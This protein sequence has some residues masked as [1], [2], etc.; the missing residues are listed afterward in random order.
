M[1]Y[2]LVSQYLLFSTITMKS[3]TSLVNGFLFISGIFVFI[4][5]YQCIKNSTI[6]LIL[7][8]FFFS[9]I[10]LLALFNRMN[11]LQSIA[12]NFSVIYILIL[13]DIIIIN[14]FITIIINNNVFF[15]LIS[16]IFMYKRLLMF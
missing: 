8:G 16:F 11:D 4:F 9:P 10:S 5:I 7:L 14:H 15:F 6:L 13:I 12:T 2:P 1:V 3:R